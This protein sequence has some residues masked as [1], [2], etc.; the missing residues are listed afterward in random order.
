MFSTA[1]KYLRRQQKTDQQGYNTSNNAD[2]YGMSE[3]IGQL[4]E[5]TQ[6]DRETVENLT[7]KNSAL[8]QDL[9]MMRSLQRAVEQLQRTVAAIQPTSV[10]D[11]P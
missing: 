6:E 3:A 4:A 8:S 11:Q 10:P 2:M 9:Q 5:A 7:Q 1:Q